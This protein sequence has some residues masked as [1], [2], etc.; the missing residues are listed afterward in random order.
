M[1]EKAVDTEMKKYL[2]LVS[3]VQFPETVSENDFISEDKTIQSPSGSV[4]SND[5]Y[6]FM[7][8]ILDKFRTATESATQTIMEDSKIDPKIRES[9]QTKIL[10]ND[11]GSIVGSW[12][13]KT[14]ILETLG[15]DKKY[16]TVTNTYTREV[17]AKELSLYES[18]LC[19]VKLLNNGVKV[20]SVSLN[21]VRQLDEQYNRNRLDAMRFS[22]L[23]KR[24]MGLK[25]EDAASI[26]NSRYQ[27][28]RANALVAKEQISSI[29]DSVR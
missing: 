27:T 12:E 17:I 5:E 24:S 7:K 18:A 28:A 14:S 29:R 26:F 16:Y 21:E 4:C 23:F 20:S 22:K 1:V 15:T 8:K 9:L 11:Q 13:I 10:P 25:Q 6:V 2:K 3:E 19:L